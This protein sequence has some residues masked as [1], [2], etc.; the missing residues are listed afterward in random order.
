MRLR[1]A[2]DLRLSGDIRL[3]SL[4]ELPSEAELLSAV[5]HAIRA[6]TP[7]FADPP[8]TRLKAAIILKKKK[9]SADDNDRGEDA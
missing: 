7:L 8:V 4:E 5:Q 3:S 6:C 2:C 1:T 9:A